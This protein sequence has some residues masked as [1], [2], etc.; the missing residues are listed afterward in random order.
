MKLFASKVSTRTWLK[1]ILQIGLGIALLGLVLY[2]G[3][4]DN[5]D[6]LKQLRWLPLVGGLGATFGIAASIALRWQTLVRS[7]YKDFAAGWLSL[8]RYFLWN[9][10][11]GFI[12]PKDLSDIGGRTATLV[13]KHDV[14]LQYAGASVLLDRVFDIVIMGLFLGPSLLFL[15]DSVGIVGGMAFMILIASGFYFLIQFGYH[16]LTDL[17]S[18]AFNLFVGLLRRLPIIR[19]RSLNKLEFFPLSKHHFS[20]A[21]FFSL[22][23]FS[24][25]ALRFVF[26]ARALA[27]PISPFVFFLSMPIGQLSFLF[28]FTPGGIGIFEAG[29]YAILAYIG[30]PHSYISPFLIEQRIF[31]II[32]IGI[33]FLISELIA[34]LSPLL[35]RRV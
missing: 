2:L 35:T 30:V 13:V 25:T 9:R 29:W 4:A 15:T 16:F 1:H 17:I 34:F 5:L 6:Q 33:L 7:F 21:Y 12:V 26:F 24:C 19:Q 31:T 18:K 11:V 8:F 3:G 22:L 10:L 20:R 28:A 14:P 23:K 27:M 32:F